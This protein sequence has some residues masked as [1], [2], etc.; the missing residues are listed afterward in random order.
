MYWVWLEKPYHAG[1]LILCQDERVKD[2]VALFAVDVLTVSRIALF[3]RQA[4]A[5]AGFSAQT[6]YL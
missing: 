1:R 5:D 4:L 3:Y 2:L 6:P